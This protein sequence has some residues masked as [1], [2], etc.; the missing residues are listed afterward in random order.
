MEIIGKITATEKNPTTIDE[1][2]FW[3]SKD[4]ILNPFDVIT[5]NHIENSK[6]YGVIEEISHITD[7]PSYLTSF[8]SCDFG[9]VGCTLN[10][11]RIGMN[12]VKARVVGN[13]EINLYSCS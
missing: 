13:T 3:T 7:T 12:F 4:R 1:F 6:T 9:D 2:Y 11:Q 10:T 5:V 8:I